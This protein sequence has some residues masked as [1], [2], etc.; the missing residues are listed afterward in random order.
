M[1]YREFLNSDQVE[2]LKL[3]KTYLPGVSKEIDEIFEVISQG[4][5]EEGYE[6][7]N[8]ECDNAYNQGFMHGQSSVLY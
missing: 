2:L 6:A 1:D 4:A 8:E 3:L 7:A 5:Y